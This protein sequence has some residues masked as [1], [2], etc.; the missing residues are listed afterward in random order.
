MTSSLPTARVAVIMR[1][2]ER[3]VLLARAI[4]SVQNQAF[5]DWVLVIVN[6]GGDPRAVDAIVKIANAGITRSGQVTVMHLS[7]RVGM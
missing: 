3:P 7:H 4:A 5:T 1:T 2:F 6:N